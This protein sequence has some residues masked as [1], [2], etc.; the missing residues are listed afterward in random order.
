MNRLVALAKI[1]RPTEFS[2]TDNKITTGEGSAFNSAA[3][4]NP[5]SGVMTGNTVHNPYLMEALLT[6][7]IA[8][9]KKDYLLTISAGI[10]LSNTYLTK[11]PNKN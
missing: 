3:A 10:N 11:T 4:Y 2:I 5:T 6:A 7:S 9:L 8:Q 1:G